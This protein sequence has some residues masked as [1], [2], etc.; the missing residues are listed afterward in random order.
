M[1]I[2]IVEQMRQIRQI[3]LSTFFFF[4]FICLSFAQGT[5]IFDDQSI[6]DFS[7]I[8]VDCTNTEGPWIGTQ[9]HPY[10]TI[11]DAYN[12]AK[13]NDTI[14]VNQGTYQ[15]TLMINK[16][17]SII[18]VDQ[19]TTIIK[20]KN[21]HTIFILNN[22]N[23]SLHNLTFQYAGSYVN[24]A[25]VTINNNDIQIS[26]CTFHH[27]K[28]GIQIQ[29][30]QFIQINNCLF[31]QTGDGIFLKN[32]LD[33]SIQSSIFTHNSIGVHIEKSYDII[34]K[35]SYHF[36]NGIGI[37]L[38]E[39]HDC[40][41]NHCGVFNNNDNRGGVFMDD[42]T[43]ITVNNSVIQ[44]NG[45]GVK[46]D[47]CDSILIT[48]STF[49]WNTHIGISM[50]EQ[51]TNIDITDCNFTKNLRYSVRGEKS[52]FT[53]IQSN[54]EKSLYGLYTEE[55]SC[56]IL[57]NWWGSAF[58]PSF[59][60]KPLRQRISFSK[61][62]ISFYPWLKAPNKKAGS[63]WAIPEN[64][65]NLGI[66]FS[67]PLHISFDQPD[68]DNDGAPDWWEIKY[69][70]NPNSYDNHY[71]LDPDD[72][73]LSNIQECYASSWDADPF[74]KDIF[75]EFDWMETIT[76]GETNK[77]DYQEFIGIIDSFADH[78][79]SLHIDLGNLGGGE[80]IPYLSN[81]NYAQL[82]DYYWNYFLHND[83]K[84]PRK[85]I[86]HYGLIC[87]YG[88]SPGF[89]VI[90]WDHLDS[91]CISAEWLKD[92]QPSRD[93]Q[94]LIIGGSIH[95]LGHT[96]GLTV[97]DFGGNDNTVATQVF[98]K[99]WFKYLPYKSCMNYWY[100]YKVLTFSDGNNGDGDF[101]DWAHMD[102]SFFSHTHFDLPD[103]YR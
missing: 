28:T 55:S 85:G 98:N 25:A 12:K 59:F 71:Q 73:G 16:S 7:Y 41:V 89:A 24:D 45:F 23:I 67:T 78:N 39:S 11:T 86:F 19:D 61:E 91:F 15:E 81:F 3:I 48:Q 5:T 92:N 22:P 27:E 56:Q 70:Y 102:L 31:Y 69:H 90:G 53:V 2:L 51:S 18:G 36:V 83:M 88:P 1:I 87:D 84:N 97:D 58:G 38:T 9:L 33:A 29:N 82:Q 44:H 26:F 103:I 37:F 63:D 8:Y 96:L 50:F 93:R 100:T 30:Q 79:I 64:I 6:N 65:T 13:D 94:N 95:E 43:H 10:Q 49:Q 4:I 101:D 52:Q 32:T 77:P 66:N 35:D 17:I 99:Q 54:F 80:Q 34:V 60:E 42:C 47:Q 72:D 74:R 46:T 40:S 62:T 68:S 21:N 75:I 57:N 14:I 20:S 76:A